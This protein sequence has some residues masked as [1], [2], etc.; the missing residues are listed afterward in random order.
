MKDICQGEEVLCDYKYSLTKD[1]PSWYVDALKAHLSK[2]G[3]GS[4]QVGPILAS[5]LEERAKGQF[6]SHACEKS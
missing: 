4:D 1:V 6:H 5:A 3:V 2:I